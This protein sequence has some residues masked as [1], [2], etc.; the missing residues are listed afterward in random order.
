[1]K[2]SS[3]DEIVE[4]Y[5]FL[6]TLV[7]EA[8]ETRF[9]YMSREEIEAEKRSVI[10]ELRADASFKLLAKF[11]AYI[12]T[13]YNK[14]IETRKKDNLS[15]KYM[16]RCSEFIKKYKEYNKP[17][18]KVCLRLPFDDILG[19]LKSWFEENNNL[20]HQECSKIKGHLKFRHWYAHGRYFKHKSPIP[21][22]GDLEISCKDI[23]NEVINRN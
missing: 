7:E 21:E 10:E 9:L 4:N 13:D 2:F 16:T 22:P 8:D 1:M 6:K 14:T 11:E 23:V 20:L 18:E 3:Y 17:R 15:E 5:I 12:R 19:E